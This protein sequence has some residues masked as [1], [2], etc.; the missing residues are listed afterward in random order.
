MTKVFPPKGQNSKEPEGASLVPSPAR[1]KERSLSSLVVSTPRVSAKSSLTGKR[2]NLTARMTI[3]SQESPF[4]S[5]EH[6]SKLE[7]LPKNLSS[8]ESYSKVAQNRRQVK[9]GI[10]QLVYLYSLLTFLLFSNKLIIW[11]F[12]HFIL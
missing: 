7:N 3:A 2:S 9:D 11:L 8:P 12:L 4:P 10:L 6:V 1:R 5:E